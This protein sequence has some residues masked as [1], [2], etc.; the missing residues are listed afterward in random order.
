M[1]RKSRAP[2]PVSQA[3]VESRQASRRF[4]AGKFF[5]VVLN[6]HIVTFS[7]GQEY[8]VDA[9]AAAVIAATDAAVEW[10]D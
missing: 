8:V 1:A 3:P 7:Q 10:K 2:D 6:G 4:F 9:A 5:G